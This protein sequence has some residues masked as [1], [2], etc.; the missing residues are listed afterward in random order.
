MEGKAPA[1]P[2]ALRLYNTLI[3]LKIKVVFLSGTLEVFREVRIRNLKKVGYHTWEKLILKWV[4]IYIYFY[5]RVDH[6]QSKL[7]VGFSIY[8]PESR[9]EHTS[10]LV[11]KSK[12]RDE[13]VGA[14]YV[15]LGN[16]GDQWSDILGTNPG[17]RTFKLP[18][19][20][21]Y[22]AWKSFEITAGTL[23]CLPT[24]FSF[25]LPQFPSPITTIS[26]NH[27]GLQNKNIIWAHFLYY[28]E[29]GL[30]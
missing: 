28:E 2:V 6:F 8:R 23:Y 27:F 29:V 26:C 3:S 20:M 10:S 7:H 24:P 9:T 16:I 11:Y 17:I 25:L 12:K 22:I 18:D 1:I 19:P 15:I 30:F 4:S 14:G 5:I 21:Y 13:L